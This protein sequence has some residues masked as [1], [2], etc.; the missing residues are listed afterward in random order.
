MIKIILSLFLLGLSFGC[1]PCIAACGPILISYV[2]GTKKNIFKGLDV[3]ILFSLARIFVYVV[4]SLVVFFLGRFTLDRLLGSFSKYIFIVGGA[5]IVLV[6]ILT[7]LGKRLEFKPWQFLQRNII[8]C[9]KKSIVLLGLI[10]GLLPCAP[11]LATLSY[12]GLISKTWTNSLLYSLYFGIGTFVSPL[13][14]LTMLAGSI[15][16]FLVDKKESYHK[17]FSF[18]CGLII[19][20]L[21][22]ELI[23]R[24]F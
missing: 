10:I 12:V 16:T 1:G 3:Y 22:L 19:I 13:I 15:P 6:G 24:A 7:A 21:G 17:I 8:E 23:G 5:F 9:D 11:L 14:L 20:F 4:L 2:V 18:I